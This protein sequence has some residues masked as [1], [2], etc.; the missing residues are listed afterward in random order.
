MSLL[1]DPTTPPI[2]RPSGVRYWVLG[3]LCLITAICYIQRNC[4]SNAEVAIRSDLLVTKQETG[5][6]LSAFFLSY[7]ICQIPSGW[8]AQSW[9]GRRTLTILAAGWS[10]ALALGALAHSFGLLLAS[11]LLLGVMQAGIFPC[12]TLILAAWFPATQRAFATGV[13]SAFMQIG[14]A[15]GVFL[16]AW[17]LTV[18]HWKTMF[19]IYAVPGLLWAAW[20]YW[21]FRNRPEEHPRVNAAEL[22]A[23]SSD[24]PRP[25]G[26]VGPTP[27]L[28][29][30]LTPS[31][32]W[33][34]M[35][36]LCR[37][38]ANRFFD[39]W[40]P[41]YLKEARKLSE[42]DA[43]FWTSVPLWAAV[44][45][46]LVGGVLS[47]WILMRTGSRRAARQGLSIV[48]LL[49]CVVC[50]VL[51]YF[52]RD[53]TTAMMLVAA[54]NFLAT[55]SQPCS[56]ALTMD[57]GGKQLA[58]V[59]AIMNTAGNIGA[60]IFP[61]TVGFLAE[62]YGWTAALILFVSLQLVAAVCW[63]FLNPYGTF[64]DPGGC[65][66]TP[67]PAE[68]MPLEKNEGIRVNPPEG[69]SVY[70]GVGR[71]EAIKKQDDNIQP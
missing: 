35:Q 53:L 49:A 64:R 60:T 2:T 67:P 69:E 61:Q 20:F 29:I 11:R 7:A 66:E 55:I 26:P 56:F 1:A 65:D 30:L 8:L 10:L 71:R 46:T 52:T 70:E 13:L 43:G 45:G 54:G 58:V 16:T 47:D 5:A 3:A 27:W 42:V 6:L 41:T 19:V 48:T 44:A 31:L 37:A 17:V 28:A 12:A 57:L 18:V 62:W 50:F 23:I 39:N 63:I 51:A 40:L 32:F 9:G 4:V 68:E 59:F 22:A 38:G 34:N 24:T 36:Q 21:W 33:L 14:S 15:I 25:R